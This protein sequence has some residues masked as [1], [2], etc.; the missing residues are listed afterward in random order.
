MSTRVHLYIYGKVQGVSFRAFV[1]R[2]AHHNAVTG[3]VCNRPDG[4]V[5]AVLEGDQ[6]AVDTVISQCREGPHFARVDNMQ[7]VE[8]PYTNTFDSFE[9]RF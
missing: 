2:Y 1:R 5:E 9:I 4:S 8:E 6:E 7:L 3:W